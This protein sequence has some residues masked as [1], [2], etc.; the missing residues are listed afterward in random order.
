MKKYTIFLAS[1]AELD[2]DKMIFE[3]FI[4]TKN[5]E[6]H[7]KK[8]FLELLTW[9]DFVVA[10]SENRTQD[11]Y[12]RA[13]EKADIFV[14]LFHTK[15]G[16]YTAEEFNVAHKQFVKSKYK[17]P[18]IFPYFKEGGEQN[19]DINKFKEK[20]DNL[21]HFYEVY[22]NYD[23]LNYKFDLQLDRLAADK[24]IKWDTFDWMRSLKYLLFAFVLPILALI[25]IYRYQQLSKPFDLTV[26]VNETRAIPDMPFEKGSLTLSYGEKQETIEFSNEAYFKELPSSMRGEEVNLKFT[27]FGYQSIDTSFSLS[28]KAILLPIKRDN[29][30][31]EVMGTIKDEYNRPINGVE[32]CVLDIKQKTDDNGRFHLT[33][34]LEK[35]KKTQR[36]SACKKGYVGYDRMSPVFKDVEINIIL[37]K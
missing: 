3:N 2:E 20:I 17:R 27:S 30:L 22:D 14:I 19:N 15:V 11:E 37:R 24:V 31:G 33:I 6:W 8:V 12:N 26:M 32:V 5:K 23:Q 1:S 10:M 13:I 9:K 35:Q 7:D 25:F 28:D 16:E 29:T 34:P 21:G 36:I 18:L 4:S